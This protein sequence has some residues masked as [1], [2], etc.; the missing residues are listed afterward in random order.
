VKVRI[1]GQFIPQ[2]VTSDQGVLIMS[3][4]WLARL[5]FVWK[6]SY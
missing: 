3:V 5:F 1:R 6:V 2:V 4:W